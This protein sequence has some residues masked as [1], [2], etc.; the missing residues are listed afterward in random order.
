MRK[1]EVIRLEGRAGAYSLL[2]SHDD[3]FTRHVVEVLPDGYVTRINEVP[4]MRRGTHDHMASAHGLTLSAMDCKTH[5]ES[6][7]LSL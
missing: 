2:Y 1:A 6:A 4:C 7:L 5:R 3:G